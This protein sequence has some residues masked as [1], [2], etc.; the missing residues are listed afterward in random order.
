MPVS[1]PTA[2]DVVGRVN[3]GEGPDRTILDPFSEDGLLCFIQGRII[4]G[5]LIMQDTFP[6]Q[7][8]PGFAG[9]DGHPVFKWGEGGRTTAEVEL[10]LA[11]GWVVALNAVIGENGGHLVL[12]VEFPGITCWRKRFAGGGTSLEVGNDF[13]RGEIP[14]VDGHEVVTPQPGPG[15]IR[16]IAQ[17]EVVV[18][19]PVGGI[20]GNGFPGSLFTIEVDPA[21]ARAFPGVDQVGEPG[22]QAA[23]SSGEG[24]QAIVVCPCRAKAYVELVAI[25][26]QSD[27][28]VGAVT[29]KRD[30]PSR[31][32]LPGVRGLDPSFDHDLA[33]ALDGLD[34]TVGGLVRPHEGPTAD[35][36]SPLGAAYICVGTTCA[37]PLTS[38]KALE[39]HLK[40]L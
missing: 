2:V 14:A 19:V 5:H 34:Q 17:E 28:A 3:P 18:L 8:F 26:P 40:G 15:A 36:E 32:V 29:G 37:L 9:N 6:E 27:V 30:D 13:R 21:P 39:D 16:L 10:S 11:S 33:A 25:L 4:R 23:R 20:P 1:S 38:P 31:S 7:A 12:K 24:R 22:S 35:L